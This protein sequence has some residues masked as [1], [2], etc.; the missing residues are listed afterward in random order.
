SSPTARRTCSASTTSTGATRTW[1]ASSPAPASTSAAR[2]TKSSAWWMDDGGWVMVEGRWGT[3]PS[4]VNHPPAILHDLPSVPPRLPR[5]GDPGSGRDRVA[6]AGPSE[7]A[8]SGLG[9]AAAGGRRLRLHDA[10]GQLPRL[11]CGVDVRRGPRA[12]HGRLRAR[13][14]VRVLPAPA[15]A[16]GVV[17]PRRAAVDPPAPP[18]LGGGT[19]VGRGGLRGAGGRRT[20]ARDGGRARPLPRPDPRVGVSRPGG[21]V[22]ARR[23]EAGAAARAPRLGR[24]AADAL[25]VGRRPCRHRAGHLGYH[26]R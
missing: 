10:V 24:R 25:P 6:T 13:R 17:V 15:G 12:R 3:A 23:R 22:G 11:P 26:G 7:R 1:K 9:A 19:E 16:D 4:I 2:R 14:G 21:N 20:R 5:P 18:R 8:R